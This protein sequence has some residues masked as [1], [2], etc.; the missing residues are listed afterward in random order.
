MHY[1]QKAHHVRQTSGVC[2]DSRCAFSVFDISFPVSPKAFWE[3]ASLTILSHL[4]FQ[5]CRI[6]QS[7]RA[8]QNSFFHLGNIS[9]DR[10][11][12]G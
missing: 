3:T 12:T 11:F 6:Q 10:Y 1:N 8:E 5:P 2:C 7:G 4:R 9:N